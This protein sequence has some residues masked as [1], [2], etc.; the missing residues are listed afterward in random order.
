MSSDKINVVVVGGG[1][2]GCSIA[3]YLAQAGARVSLLERGPLCGE[4]S[5]AAAGL[6]S[7]SNKDGLMLTL[8][9][10]SLRLMAELSEDHGID[11]ELAA[12]GNLVLLRTEEELRRQR[13][14]VEKQRQSGMDIHFL[15]PKAALEMEP[16]LSPDILGASY[17]PMDAAVNPYALTLAFGAAARRLGVTI[18]TGVEVTALKSEGG[19]VSTAVTSEGEVAGDILVVAAGA[20]TPMLTR[21]VGLDLPI[22]P[23]R[24]QILV[25]QPQGPMIRTIVRDAGHMY[26][27]PTARGNYVI[28]SM[29]ERVGFDKRLT[30]ARLRDY[31]AEAA[32]LVPA[33]AGM[34]I[35]RAWTGLRPLTPDSQPILGKVEGYDGL[36]LAAGHSR[37][38]ICFSAITGKML[39]NLITTGDAGYPM[40]AFSIERL[41]A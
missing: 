5:A 29:T 10:E 18:R 31:V 2:I 12:R 4:S 26:V 8:V 16:A 20:W 15:D 27:N 17:S 14:F 35:A 32:N 24:G 28:G 23:S 6:L 3:Y 1:A 39:A 7:V 11:F 38:G 36:I 34:R 30:R 22:E 19:R 40:D 25:T 33:V 41:A 21:T 13:A 9:Q 37:T